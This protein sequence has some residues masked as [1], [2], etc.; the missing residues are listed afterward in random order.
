MGARP[1]SSRG[2]TCRFAHALSAASPPCLLTLP[3]RP[4]APPASSPHL[5]T[6]LAPL[7]CR[8]RRLCVPVVHAPAGAGG[9]HGGFVRLCGGHAA[10]ALH[11]AAPCCCC[12]CCRRSAQ[13]AMEAA[14]ARSRRSVAGGAPW[15]AKRTCQLPEMSLLPATL[16]GSVALHAWLCG[17]RHGARLMWCARPSAWTSPKSSSEGW[18]EA[19]A[20]RWEPGACSLGQPAAACWQVGGRDSSWLHAQRTRPSRCASLPCVTT[21][22]RRKQR[23]IKQGN[24]MKWC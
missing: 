19:A 7:T 14:Y 10:G 21:A 18:P 23:Q 9:Q 13:G 4:A 22:G 6:L 17:R 12:C 15:P 2:A 8:R 1:C 16:R 11:G 24:Q 3:A 20:Q 5:A